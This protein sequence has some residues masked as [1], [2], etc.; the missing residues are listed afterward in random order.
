MLHG[1]GG[2]GL[3]R[4]LEQLAVLLAADV[5]CGEHAVPL[6]LQQDEPRAD[7][8][9]HDDASNREIED[10]N[11][12]A[13]EAVGDH[14][15]RRAERR[16]GEQSDSSAREANR[17]RARQRL[18]PRHRGM[19]RGDPE[20]PVRDDPAGVDEHPVHV[21]ALQSQVAVRNVRDDL[22]GNADDEEPQSRVLDP[23]AESQLHDPEQQNHVEHRC[24]DGDGHACGGEPSLGK[25]RLD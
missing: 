25:E 24:R 15:D 5:D 22:A 21:A 20:Q 23:L 14:H 6:P 13:A 16:G 9:R 10:V 3:V 12:I 4:L 18:D 19:Q 17:D 8:E 1:Q 7:E 2:A 11:R